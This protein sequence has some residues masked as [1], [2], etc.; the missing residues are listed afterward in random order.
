MDEQKRY[1]FNNNLNINNNNQMEETEQFNPKGSI[2]KES[3]SPKIK[4]KI[5]KKITARE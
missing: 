4:K 5:L 2:N 3:N 1:F